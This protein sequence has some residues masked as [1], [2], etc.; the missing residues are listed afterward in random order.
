MSVTY[1]P[2]E[3]EGFT[4]EMGMRIKGGAY[5]GSNQKSLRLIARKDYG[6]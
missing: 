1:L 2:A 6:E 5:R 4:Q 3:G